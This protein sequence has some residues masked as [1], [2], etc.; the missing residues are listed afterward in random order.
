[1]GSRKHLEGYSNLVFKD[2][3]CWF[4]NSST[5]GDTCHIFG[6]YFKRSFRIFQIAKY[7]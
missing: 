5:D 1:M 3:R 2:E 4:G 6:T 7:K